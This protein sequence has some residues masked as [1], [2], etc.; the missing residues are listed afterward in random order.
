MPHQPY[1][2]EPWFKDEL[3]KVY[4]N[5]KYNQ[6]WAQDR[7]LHPFFQ[8]YLKLDNYAEAVEFFR[9]LDQVSQKVTMNQPFL[10]PVMLTYLQENRHHFEV[11]L[12][13]WK[14]YQ[15]LYPTGEMDF[16]RYD[17]VLPTILSFWE[18]Q[19]TPDFAQIMSDYE[20][21]LNRVEP[22]D[23]IKQLESFSRIFV[24]PNLEDEVYKLMIKFQKTL[25]QNRRYLAKSLDYNQVD[26]RNLY[27]D[28]EAF[29]WK[30][31]AYLTIFQA[32][33][34]HNPGYELSMKMLQK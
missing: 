31:N 19:L 13:V 28:L 18:A 4:Q 2:F 5:L 12:E 22:E 34:N 8:Q 15:H 16:S 17:Q 10:E 32:W 11:L 9:Q 33:M 30:L 1:Y 27:V 20:P 3:N 21:L 6:F 7:D 26:Q 29:R 24:E 23:F 14:A 25:N